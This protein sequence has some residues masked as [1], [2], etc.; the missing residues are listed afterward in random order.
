MAQIA[1]I[2]VTGLDPWELLA[3]LHN[4]SRPSPT[5]LC[6][7]I[8]AGA[9]LRRGG[10]TEI[11]A[12]EARART[13]EDVYPRADLAIPRWPDYLFGRPIKAEL[14]RS[15]GKILLSQ[16]HRYDHAVGHGA[17]EAVVAELREAAL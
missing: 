5:R 1:F 9:D 14:V 2:D 3:A 15:E 10:R 17:A 11:T 8:A 13:E 12:A 6:R 7:A 16:T 4:A